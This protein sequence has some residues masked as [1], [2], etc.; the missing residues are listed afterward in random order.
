MGYEEM[1]YPEHDFEMLY[2]DPNTHS[3]IDVTEDF[4]EAC[5]IAG[6]RYFNWSKILDRIKDTAHYGQY[7]LYA[8]KLTGLSVRCDTEWFITCLYRRAI[9]AMLIK[10]HLEKE[11]EE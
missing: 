10:Q 8:P 3:V 1:V 4:D 7:K 9:D 11:K 2:Y 5:Q 6:N